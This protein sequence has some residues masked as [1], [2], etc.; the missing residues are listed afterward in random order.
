MLLFDVSSVHLDQ[1]VSGLKIG[2][3]T[4]T[5][6]FLARRRLRTPQNRRQ[7]ESWTGCGSA[8]SL[9]IGTSS[10]SLENG[11]GLV[12]YNASAPRI[13]LKNSTSGT[14]GQLTVL[15]LQWCLLMHT[16]TIVKRVL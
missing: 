8:E 12:V 14:T 15:I 2:T 11:S 9:G 6:L 13:S 5:Q 1:I 4:Q 7:R 10:P 16:F 3:L